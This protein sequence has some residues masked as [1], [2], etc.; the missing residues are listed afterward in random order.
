MQRIFVLIAVFLS[1]G[2]AQTLRLATT[3]SVNDSG[4]LD[5]LLPAF[6]QKTGIKVEV[7]AVGT[8]Q[9]LALARRGDADAVLVHAP[10]L[11]AQFLREGFG[12][13]HACLA[14]NNF[15]IAG[16]REDPAKIKSA[17]NALEAFRRIAATGSLFI[18]RGDKSGTNAKELSLW[19][20]AGIT[21]DA[22][23]YLESGS[24]MGATLT[25]ASEKNAYTLTDLA[26]LLA[27]SG[28]LALVSL[29]DK[30]YQ[31][32]LNQYSYMAVNPGKFPKANYA[33]AGQ[34]RAFLLAPLTQQK[35]GEFMREKYGQRLFT[36]LYGKC[37]IAV[38]GP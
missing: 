32:M 36:P 29:V 9:A 24:G 23:W 28:K 18:S 31:E 19:K 21:P 16:P 5:Y 15:V 4:L 35:I 1:L 8:G 10:E 14:Y 20:Q 3:T 6:S 22:S 11:E 30:P 34:L 37:K 17:P 33:A 25:V 26:T 7:V 13:D 27:F 2:W 12:R 38:S